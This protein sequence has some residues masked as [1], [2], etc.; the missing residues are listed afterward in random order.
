M[1]NI[2]FA[3]FSFLP[4]FL[5]AQTSTFDSV[6]CGCADLTP[7]YELLTGAFPNNPPVSSIII[8]Y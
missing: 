5:L 7:K 3:C 4:L 6:K 1:K 2:F 8:Q